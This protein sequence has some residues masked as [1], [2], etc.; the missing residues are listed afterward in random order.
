MFHRGCYF[1]L[2]TIIVIQGHW[3]RDH[4][5]TYYQHLTLKCQS[6]FSLPSVHKGRSTWTQPFLSTFPQKS[7]TKLAPYLYTPKTTIYHPKQNSK[8][9]PF[10]NGG[11]E[12]KFSL[13]KKKKS[14]DQNLKNHFSKG[15]L[16]KIWLKV[17]QH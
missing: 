7:G 3:S 16:N 14:C 9:V 5:S 8:N 6:Y 13:R 2:W 10:Q 12:N 11:Q 1:R 4:K 15:I 17:G